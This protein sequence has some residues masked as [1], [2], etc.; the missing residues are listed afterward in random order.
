[1][2]EPGS[3]PKNGMPNDPGEDQDADEKN[4]EEISSDVVCNK[5]TSFRKVRESPLETL[6]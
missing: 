4:K 5:N 1:M 2:L 6:V 3:D